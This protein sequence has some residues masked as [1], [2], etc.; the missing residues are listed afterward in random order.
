MSARLLHQAQDLAETLPPLL[1]E[2]ERVAQA[3]QQGI[4]G[5]RRAGTGETFWQFR[6][7]E[8][9]DPAERIDWRQSS[10]TDKIFVR[11]REWEAAQSAYLWADNSGSMH[12][13]SQKSL[14]TK[15][16]RARLLML[17]LANLLLRGGEKV[18]WMAP[19]AVTVFGKTGLEQI[20]SRLEPSAKTQSLPPNIHLHRHAHVILASDFL[21]PIAV[22]QETMRSYAAR[23]LH[24][25]L[26]H[27]IDPQEEDFTLQGRLEMQGCEG[28]EHLLLP[29]ASALRDAYQARMTEHKEQLMLMAKSAGWYYTHH[30]THELPH[31]AL[32][33]LYQ[34]LDANI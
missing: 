19:K 16:E 33:R 11:E 24:G 13:T 8:Q 5:R 12:Y 23:N 34:F 26:L 18:T 17:A 1:I 31:L 25:V 30:V 9:G 27:I 15:A 6:R 21:M 22:L 4:H 28:E 29:N 7:Y 10:R 14:P 3:V 2:A 32:M 20:I